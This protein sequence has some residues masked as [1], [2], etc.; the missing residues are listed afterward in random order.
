MSFL[1]S[2][3]IFSTPKLPKYITLKDA[4]LSLPFLY[5]AIQWVPV[6]LNSSR[7]I[8]YAPF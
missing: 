6:D 1:I 4:I 8:A 3:G 7:F 5:K 2:F